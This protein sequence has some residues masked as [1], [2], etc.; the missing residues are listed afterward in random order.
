MTTIATEQ[1]SL[2]LTPLVEPIYETGM[3]L[4]ERFMAFHVANPHVLDALEALAD[5]WLSRHSKVSVKALVE[6]LRWESGISTHGDP[7]RL[8]NSWTAFYARL[9]VERRP[10]WADC[11]EFRLAHAEA[12]APAHSP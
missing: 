4:T 3:T 9:L 7:Y 11:I 12:L 6:R 1:L 10:Q 2:D 8:N 5:Q